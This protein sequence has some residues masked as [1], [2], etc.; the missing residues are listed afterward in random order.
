MLLWCVDYYSLT[1]QN[2]DSSDQPGLFLLWDDFGMSWSI[3]KWCL[4]THS[5]NFAHVKAGGKGLWTWKE[6]SLIY[7]ANVCVGQIFDGVWWLNFKENRSSCVSG[8]TGPGP[9]SLSCLNP[10]LGPQMLLD[11]NSLYP[12]LLAKLGQDYVHC[13]STKSGDPKLKNAG[14]IL[15]Y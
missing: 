12:W 9:V 4:Y 15:G 13:S 7:T 1:S 8:N 5:V 3:G 14:I 2:S 6:Q 11:C 10:S